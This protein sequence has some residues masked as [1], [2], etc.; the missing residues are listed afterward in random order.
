MYQV[1][2]LYHHFLILTTTLRK[3]LFISFLLKML[4]VSGLGIR[5]SS[6]IWKVGRTGITQ[7]VHTP[8]HC[9]RLQRWPTCSW[10]G[11]QIFLSMCL[12]F[13]LESYLSLFPDLCISTADTAMHHSDPLQ[14]WRTYSPRYGECSWQAPPAIS[15]IW[16]CLT[17]EAPTQ[18]HMPS[19]EQHDGI[20]A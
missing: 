19:Q 6:H 20:K 7:S 18:G 13:G 11:T 14:D 17:K 12:C 2:I 15:P 9:S 3:R 1:G 4:K 8:N 16:N 10:S 5:L